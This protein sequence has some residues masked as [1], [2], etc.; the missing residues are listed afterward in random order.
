MLPPALHKKDIPVGTRVLV[1]TSLNLPTQDGAV[2][3]AFRLNAALRTVVFLREKGAR[4]TLLS[5]LSDDT[6]SLT[7]VHKVLN[8]RIP[9]SF[10][11]Q[12]T[13]EAPY[14]ARKQLEPGEV[15]L[16]EN[17][18]TD[19]RERENDI[20]FAEELAAQ[21]DLFVFD[22]FT[23]AHRSH[24]STVGLIQ[25]LPSCAG[26]QFYE[27]LTALLRITER[28]ETPAVAVVSG[29]KCATKIP[30]IARLAETY[31]TLFIGGVIANT[32]LRYKGYSVGTSKT[33]EV[34]VPD[35]VANGTNVILPQ[36][37]IV[38]KDYISHR[39]IPVERVEDDDIIVDVGDRT[40]RTMWYHFENAK[41]IVM[42][43]PTGWYEKGFMKQTMLITDLIKKSG[44]Y[45]FAGGGDTVALLE[46][47]NLL[48]GWHFIS[49]GGGSL[50]HYLANGT[51]PVLQALN[52]A[53]RPDVA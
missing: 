22:D 13:G 23:A 12:L 29:A 30:L 28:M 21:T 43:G 2:T 7:S 35:A 33:E 36:E 50:L 44:A 18:R 49:T 37:V 27:E 45:T 11:P 14:A 17:T 42:N 25:C 52:G 15:L 9:V 10:I 38:T 1:R 53:G 41:T 20:L 26:I 3:S 46:Q 16:L 32:L 4:I 48:D 34:V 31:D 5:H 6:A 19:K 51:L 40:L 8:D 39:M 24:A 47:R